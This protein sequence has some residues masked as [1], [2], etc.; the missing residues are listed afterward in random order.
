MA[1]A[2]PNAVGGELLSQGVTGQEGS[3]HSEVG[4][5]LGSS[6]SDPA[7]RAAR[8]V[9]KCIHADPD[10]GHSWASSFGGVR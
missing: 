10:G 1:V 3:G 7:V 8:A 9:A 6:S 4:K 2:Q 5:W